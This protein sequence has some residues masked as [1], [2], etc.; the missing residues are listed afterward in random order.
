MRRI[1]LIRQDMGTRILVFCQNEDSTK[2]NA[3]EKNLFINSEREAVC[4]IWGKRKCETRKMEIEDV[5]FIEMYCRLFYV[6][7]ATYF[8][9]LGGKVEK[10][11]LENGSNK[12][13]AVV[14]ILE[15]S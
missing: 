4:V 13:M 1:H 7:A 12:A 10:V 5:M 9:K 2:C 3:P 6:D 8:I 15:N 11:F 14:R